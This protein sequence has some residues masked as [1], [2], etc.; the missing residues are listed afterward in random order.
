MGNKAAGIVTTIFLFCVCAFVGMLGGKGVQRAFAVDNETP[1][2][3]EPSNDFTNSIGIAFVKIEP[4]EFMMGSPDSEQGRSADEV[5]HRVKLTKEFFLAKNLITQGQWK[6]IMGNNPSNFHGD[7]LPVEMMPW[8]DADAFCKKLSEKEG[9]NY[10]LPTEAEWEFVCRAG[11]NTACYFGGDPEQ[12][13]DY[14]WWGLNSS[15]HTQPVGLKKPNAWGLYDMVGNVRQ[16]CSDWYGDYPKADQVDPQ[17]PVNGDSRVLRGG[18]F[19]EGPNHCRSAN[20]N[21]SSPAT[22]YNN[23]G[24]R[25]VLDVK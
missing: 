17:G 9:R 8:G 12:L 10:R 22:G 6:A 13:G 15:F 3:T 24:F 16:W 2:S 21:S 20:R 25:P 18:A 5:Q 1:P 11:T 14:A 4:G 19:N 23:V 7:G